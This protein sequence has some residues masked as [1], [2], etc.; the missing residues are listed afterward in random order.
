MPS[1]PAPFYAQTAAQAFGTFKKRHL[2]AVASGQELLERG[3]GADV[4]LAADYGVS[5]TVPK[6]VDGVLRNVG[7]SWAS[8]FHQI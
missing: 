8:C 6:L 3:F 5:Q 1:R 2:L 7:R 4:E